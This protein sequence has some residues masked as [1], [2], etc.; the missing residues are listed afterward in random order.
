MRWSA[1]DEWR[2]HP[3]VTDPQRVASNKFHSHSPRKFGYPYARFATAGVN[4]NWGIV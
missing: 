1:W 4:P 2:G 3:W